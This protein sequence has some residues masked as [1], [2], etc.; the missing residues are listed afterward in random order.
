MT[1]AFLLHLHL[2][3]SKGT[4]RVT[5][6]GLVSGDGGAECTHLSL[7]SPNAHCQ[8]R[9]FGSAWLRHPAARCQVPPYTRFPISL[10]VYLS[11]TRHSPSTI[12]KK[13]RQELKSS[14]YYIIEINSRKGR[15]RKPHKLN[16]QYLHFRFSSAM[17]F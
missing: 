1:D 16:H 6:T 4:L 9:R 11:F 3:S 15:L 13:K 2:H 12:D 5:E 10:P 14:G 17:H 7:H 8:Y